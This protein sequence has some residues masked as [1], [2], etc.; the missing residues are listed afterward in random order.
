MAAGFSIDGQQILQFAA[1]LQADGDTHLT[2]ED[3]IPTIVADAEV[4]VSEAGPEVSAQLA[5]LE[6][7]GQGNPEPL[8]L[9]RDLKVVNNSPTSNPDHARLLLQGAS[10]TPRQAMAFGIGRRLASTPIGGAID[11]LFRTEESMWNGAAQFRWMIQDYRS[12]C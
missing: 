9:C 6:P 4:D 1:R 12:S 2:D 11:V 5:A 10:G 8:F 7:F 3:L